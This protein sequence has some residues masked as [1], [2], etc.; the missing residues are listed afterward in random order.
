VTFPPY[1]SAFGAHQQHLRTLFARM[2][3]F[4]LVPFGLSVVLPRLK[5]EH[6]HIVE[7]VKKLGRLKMGMASFENIVTE[8]DL[9]VV[10]RQAYLISPNHIRFG[11]RPVSAGPLS[12]IPLIRE[13]MCSG[14][15]YL[16]SKP[17]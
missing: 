3:F 14:V 15:V 7:E 11:L 9:R 2:P 12:R 17:E 1:Y 5:N 13:I 10:H 6:P 16:L 8:G 4:H